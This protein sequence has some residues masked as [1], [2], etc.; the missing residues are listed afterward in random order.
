[1]ETQKRTTLKLAIDE[2]MELLNS[3]YFTNKFSLGGKTVTLPKNVNFEI[4]LEG[5]KNDG[6]LEFEFSWSK[7]KKEINPIVLFLIH[8]KKNSSSLKGIENIFKRVGIT[9]NIKVVPKKLNSRKLRIF[10]NKQLSR[11][12]ELFFADEKISRRI[13]EKLKI[14]VKKPILTFT[15][16]MENRKTIPML[17]AY[18][19]GLKYVDIAES[20]K[21]YSLTR[22]QK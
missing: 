4:E 1:M 7:R 19:L 9:Y 11:G 22:S 6:E 15:D 13:N 18:I 2:T 3:L 12:V 10:L 20:Y 5:N 8:K 14:Y 21:K 17:A 16:D